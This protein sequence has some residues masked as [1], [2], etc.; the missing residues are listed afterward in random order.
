MNVDS[1]QNGIVIDHITPGRGMEIYRYLRL[2]ELDCT[3]AIMLNVRS[4]KRGAKDLIKIDA[5]I[6]LN[7]DVL[8]FIDPTCT[9]NVIENGSTVRKFSPELPERLTGVLHCR[10][11]RCITQAESDLPHIFVLSDRKKQTYRCLYCETIGKR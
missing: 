10:N 5:P 2:D 3:V 4:T 7:V 6:D 11:P 8:G 9:V 1:I